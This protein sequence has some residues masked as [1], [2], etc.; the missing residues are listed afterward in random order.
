VHLLVALLVALP[1][2]QTPTGN[3]TCF[4]VPARPAHLL[5]SIRQAAYA[6]QEQAA[7]MAR[8]GLDWH[9]WEVYAERRAEPV[10][11]GGVLYNTNRNVPRPH[12]LPYGR[13]WRFAAFTCTSR[14]TGLTCTGSSGAGITISRQAWSRR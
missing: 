7:C 10:C 3:I 8:S 4:Y 13:S 5:C 1:G 6:R 12:V 14:R 2:V 9:G 11:S